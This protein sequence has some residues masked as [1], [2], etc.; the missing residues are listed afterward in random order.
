MR[1]KPPPVP[2]AG[3]TTCRVEAHLDRLYGY[4]LHLAAKPD[5][6]RDLVQTCAMKALCAKSV[7]C[8]AAA[9]RTW[10]FRILR[11]TWIDE[12][13]RRARQ[14]VS[15]DALERDGGTAGNDTWH[16][17]VS[18]VEKRLFNRLAV[19]EGLARIAPDHREVLLLVDLAGFSY[20]EAAE[21]LEVPIGTV[22][23]RVSRARQR[24]MEALE[25]PA[26][27]PLRLRL[28]RRK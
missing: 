5:D 20:K 25:E 22:M 1:G 15:W 24:L 13:R 19:R 4:A 18:S 23:S 6:A 27:K 8:D 11:N 7:P 17:D 28:V 10:L 2:G 16:P 14:P 3:V 12:C 9:Y 21:L 26:V